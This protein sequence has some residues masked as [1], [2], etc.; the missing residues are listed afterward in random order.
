MKS[1][2]TCLWPLAMLYALAA[3]FSVHADTVRTR[4][5]RIDAPKVAGRDFEVLAT[6][7]GRVYFAPASDSALIQ[8]LKALSIGNSPVSLVTDESG[9]QILSADALRPAEAE[10]YSD[11]FDQ[12]QVQA[13]A[14]EAMGEARRTDVGSGSMALPKSLVSARALGYEP[15]ILD[16][17]FAAQTLFDSERE[18]K[19]KSQ[20]YERAQV[21]TREFEA[22]RGVKSMKVF[23]FF[24]ER[25]RH[26][27]T[28]NVMGSLWTKPYKWWFH[29]APFVYVDGQDNVEE[30]VLDR[31]FLPEAVKMND[32]TFEFIGKVRHDDK[33]I[34]NPTYGEALCQDASTY[35][36]FSANRDHP[37]YCVLRKVPMYYFQ[38][39]NLDALDCRQGSTPT[40]CVRTVV[41]GWQ[42]WELNKAYRNTK[43]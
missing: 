34:P 20:C 2:V 38:P 31:E 18:L 19:H 7:D 16:T 11:D 35:R 12:P 8:K 1:L 6:G 25:F 5:F 40:T 27:F 26:R 4:I 33:K 29:V 36:D 43:R 17:V 21:W 9:E 42:D 37:R 15:T 28:H 39:L 13:E 22:N 10:A 32:W 30:Y 14:Y 41:S 23:M 3:P 24:T